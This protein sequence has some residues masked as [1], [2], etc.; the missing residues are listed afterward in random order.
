MVQAWLPNVESNGDMVSAGPRAI[1]YVGRIG[2]N[3]YNKC[4]YGTGQRRKLL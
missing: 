4:G 3:L 1:A 2:R